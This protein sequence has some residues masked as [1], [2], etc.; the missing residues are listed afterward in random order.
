MTLT[1]IHVVLLGVLLYTQKCLD[2]MCEKN[3]PDIIKDSLK[4]TVL[5]IPASIT[6]L[7]PLYLLFNHENTS[8]HMNKIIEFVLVSYVLVLSITT[9]KKCINPHSDTNTFNY[10]LPLNLL[11]N[12]CVCY[13]GVIHP[14]HQTGFMLG[15][16]LMYSFLSF[17]QKD[18]C[19]NTSSIIN[20]TVLS[21]LVFV[22]SKHSLAL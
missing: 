4:Q 14:R 7:I 12:L 19:T 11:L 8:N 1:P 13:Y 22:L 16:V 3:N 15:N 10:T 18:G 17:S 6:L 9:F 20:D 2:T 21:L 5:Q